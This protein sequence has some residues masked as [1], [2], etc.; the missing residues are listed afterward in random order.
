MDTVRR[1]LEHGAALLFPKRCSFCGRVVSAGA[2][3]CDSC[4]ETLPFIK[5]DICP[6]CGRERAQCV[7]AGKHYAFDRLIAPFYYDGLAKDAIWRVKFRRQ[8]SLAAGLGVIAAGFARNKYSDL[9]FDMAVPV[10]MSRQEQRDRGFNQSA[11]FCRSMG[12]ELGIPTREDVLAKP[13]DTKPQRSCHKEMRWKNVSGVFYAPQAEAV[14]GKNILLVDDVTTTGA[15]LNECA[16]VLKA[17]GAKTICC[18]AVAAVRM[19]RQPVI[20]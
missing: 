15:T 12:R 14:R 16:K 17:A 11:L 20:A 18:V 4:R 6:V 19:Q 8:K 9:R 7:C 10:P 13:L 2:T 1:W 5:G 3:V